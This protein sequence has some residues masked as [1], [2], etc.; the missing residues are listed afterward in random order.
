MGS[1]AINHNYGIIDGKGSHA[2]GIVG[3]GSNC[4]MINYCGNHGTIKSSSGESVGGIVGEIGDPSNWTLKN[5][6]NCILGTIEITMGIIG[7]AFAMYEL[8][9]GKVPK[10]LLCMENGVNIVC[11]FIDTAMLTWDIYNMAT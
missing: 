5:T 1:L 8:K 11:G 6:A 4:T 9:G 10:A 2:G 3:L 7:P